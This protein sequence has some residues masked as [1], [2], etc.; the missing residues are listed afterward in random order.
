MIN[1]KV[2]CEVTLDSLLQPLIA[3]AERRFLVWVEA[4]DI[5][6]E[7]SRWTAYESFEHFTGEEAEPLYVLVC[8]QTDDLEDTTA[9]QVVNQNRALLEQ[10]WKDSCWVTRS[11]PQEPENQWRLLDVFL[12]T[13][14]EEWF[15]AKYQDH[16]SN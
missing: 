8:A 10:C 11:A 7:S 2:T 9:C 13:R 15:N 16:L 6:K 1:A 14:V 4:E 3:V 12:K 5:P